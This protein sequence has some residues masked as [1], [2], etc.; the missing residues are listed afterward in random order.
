MPL[1]TVELGKTNIAHAFQTDGST[2][3]GELVC[4]VEGKELKRTRY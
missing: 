1:R 2:Y 4:V 3:A